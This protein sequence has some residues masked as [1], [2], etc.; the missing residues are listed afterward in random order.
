VHHH[1]Q[2]LNPASFGKLVRVLF[3]DIGTRRLGIRGE[4]KYHYVDL[5]LADDLAEANGQQPRHRPSLSVAGSEGPRR[6]FDPSGFGPDSAMMTG[7]DV[8][9]GNSGEHSSRTEAQARVFP[10]PY[11]PMLHPPRPTG[12]PSYTHQIRFS[13][14]SILQYSAIDDIQLPNIWDYCSE[15]TDRD[16]VDALSTLYLAHVTSLIDC[17]RYC[18]EKT[19]FKL[20][21]SFQGTLTVPV[22]KLYVH[23]DLA[24]WVK[25]C[26]Y[27]MYQS[28][29]KVLGP[30]TL[31][32]MPTKVMKFLNSVSQILDAHLMKTLDQAP[33][34]L[35]DAKLE[36]ANIFMSL[37][38]RMLRTNQAAHAAGSVLVMDDN[39]NRMWA[40][41]VRF[42]NPKQ[43]MSA[44]VPDCGFDEEVYRMLT[45]DLRHL[46]LPLSTPP[47]LEFN[48]H[49]QVAAMAQSAVPQPESFELDKMGL[50]FESLQSR[51]P[52]PS[53]ELTL[54]VQAVTSRVMRDIVMEHGESY[55][56]WLIAMTFIDELILWL[57]HAGGFLERKALAAPRLRMQ[58]Q[59][60]RDKELAGVSGRNGRSDLSG[61]ESRYTSSGPEGDG[62]NGRQGTTTSING[63]VSSASASVSGA[64][65]VHSSV[66]P[67]AARSQ[68]ECFASHTSVATSP[69][70]K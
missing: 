70:M 11:K 12:V 62:S 52:I 46:L 42:S 17:V 8:A 48:T 41:Y 45:Y 26:D 7:G 59:Q 61:G 40:E 38:N 2:P 31:Q 64:D 56:C 13:S 30:L 22:Q 55:N 33:Q 1:L 49:F 24:P 63:A 37:L 16:A 66:A 47:E 43:T 10:D 3:P 44:V 20:Y 57:G 5:S 58:A 53:R 35:V 54:L 29:I 65:S 34:H 19:F 18:R 32:V 39:R 21:T 69:E 9:M 60:A 36:P 15:K 4:S 51:L 68:S 23:S 27:L 25:E 6:S 28:M 50:F 14:Q 67:T